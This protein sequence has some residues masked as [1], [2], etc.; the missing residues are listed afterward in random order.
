MVASS[1][2]MRDQSCDVVSKARMFESQLTA[3]PALFWQRDLMAV[4]SDT[5]HYTIPVTQDHSTATDSSVNQH[6]GCYH[7][8]MKRV[9]VPWLGD[10]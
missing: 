10:C 3:G 6:H 7:S 2:G 9:H 8:I 4:V 1:D 5:Y